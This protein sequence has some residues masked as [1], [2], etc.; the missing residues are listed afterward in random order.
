MRGQ[1]GRDRAAIA[2]A[3]GVKVLDLTRDPDHNRS[4][5]TFVGPPEQIGEGAVR[6]VAQAVARSI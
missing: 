2:S 4:V 3:P 5:I 6:G 1:S